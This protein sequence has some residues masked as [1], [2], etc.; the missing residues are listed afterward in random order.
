[1]YTNFEMVHCSNFE[2]VHY[3]N[4]EWPGVSFSS[5]PGSRFGVARGLVLEWP[6]SIGERPAHSFPALSLVLFF[7]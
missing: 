1:M 6:G 2:L 4:L 3:S 7:A 5:C